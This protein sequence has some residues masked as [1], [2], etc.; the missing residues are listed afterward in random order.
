MLDYLETLFSESRDS[1][2]YSSKDDLRSVIRISK[3]RAEKKS[4]H[5]PISENVETFLYTVGRAARLI[6]KLCEPVCMFSMHI[7]YNKS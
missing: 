2:L 6:K 1:V 7:S 4:P 5:I 3:N